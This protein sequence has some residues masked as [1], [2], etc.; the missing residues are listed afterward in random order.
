M[1]MTL[2]KNYLKGL[3]DEIQAAMNML[4]Q[5]N[6][7]F[8]IDVAT[9]ALLDQFGDDTNQNRPGEYIDDDAAY[10][11]LIRAIWIISRSSGTLPEMI[12]A[13]RVCT[14]GTIIHAREPSIFVPS[15]FPDSTPSGLSLASPLLYIFSNSNDNGNANQLLGSKAAGVS[16]EVVIQSQASSL[17]SAVDD[18]PESTAAGYDEGLGLS[19]LDCSNLSVENFLYSG[20]HI[21]ELI[22][23]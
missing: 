10:R 8:N 3:G 4:S 12:F 22:T 21:G 23:R 5:I 14:G 13:A 20:G 19:E 1:I 16:L 7:G 17:V 18:L 11:N 15:P 9:G 2:F 6:T